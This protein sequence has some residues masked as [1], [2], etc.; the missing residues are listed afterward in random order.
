MK[1][2]SKKILI[3]IAVVLAVIVLG[4]L[5]SF[6]RN[7]RYFRICFRKILKRKYRF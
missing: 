3:T 4:P 6:I 2:K 1:S 5:E 7:A